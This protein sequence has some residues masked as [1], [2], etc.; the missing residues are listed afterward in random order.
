M[1]KI[2]QFRTMKY[3]KVAQKS[4]EWLTLRNNFIT[5]S[6]VYKLFDKKEDNYIEY[7]KE[8]ISGISS[9]KGNDA[10]NFG[11]IFEPVA[12][13]VYKYLTGEHVEEFGLIT[14]DDLPYCA[15]SPDGVTESDRLL[16][17]KCPYTRQITGT[18]PYG[19][20]HQIQL[21]L[22]VCDCDECDFFECKFKS[23][24]EDEYKAKLKILEVS[25]NFMCL[26]STYNF[27]VECYMNGYP[28][29]INNIS[30]F[31][32]YT[33]TNSLH[34]EVL[35]DIP[36][37]GYWI[38]NNNPMYYELE[39]VSLQTIQRNPQWINLHRKDLNETIPFVQACRKDPR[40]LDNLLNTK[41][42]C[43][44]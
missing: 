30:T 13:E 18:V 42:I 3:A 38:K 39:F 10:T 2:H 36:L 21:Q 37:N 7:L 34:H 20:Y 44:L 4:S 33:N 6:N 27:N 40:L 1:N 35:T 5:A 8:K 17:I 41:S 26:C 22:A 24:S 28:N 23:I 9:F 29:T 16:E 31:T 19:Y 43:E 14:N 25:S 12:R 11:E 32:R 15:V